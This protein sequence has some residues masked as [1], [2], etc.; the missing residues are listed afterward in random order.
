[1]PKGVNSFVGERGFNLSGGQSQRIA[2]ARALYKESKLLI[3]DE[4]TSALD[5]ET[6]RKIIDGIY[7]KNKDLTIISIAHRK[8]ALK[9]CNK[10]IELSN[11]EII[12]VLKGKF[13]Y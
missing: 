9:Y 5:N 2:I 6:E 10:I 1:M 4:A 13:N 11:G 8:E 12:N 3:L 7:K